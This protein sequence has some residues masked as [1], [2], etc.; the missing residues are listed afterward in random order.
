MTE[1]HDSA[2]AQRVSPY[3][4]GPEHVSFAGMREQTGR[5][6]RA[7]MS[8]PCEARADG[9]L[10]F[11]TDVSLHGLRVSHHGHPGP[12]GQL[13]R[14]DFEWEGRRASV[15]AELRW[16]NIQSS[17]GRASYA[18]SVYDAGFKIVEAS[19]EAEALLHELML[20]DAFARLDEKRG[21]TRRGPSV[22]VQ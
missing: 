16:C 3:Q 7:T 1:R 22:R 17:I 18:K 9:R 5:L 13:R 15:V 6:H 12:I 20:D 10:T 14:I 11:I 2:D 4:I 8:R 21:V 19:P